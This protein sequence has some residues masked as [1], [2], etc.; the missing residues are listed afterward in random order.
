MYYNKDMKSRIVTLVSGVSLALLY[1]AYLSSTIDQADLRNIRFEQWCA[2]TAVA[3]LYLSLLSSSLPGKFTEN[4]GN[5]VILSF[6]FGLLHGSISFFFLL[7]GFEGLAFLNGKWILAITLSTSALLLLLFMALVHFF[8]GWSKSRP[9]LSYLAYLAGTMLMVHAI[10]VGTHFIDLSAAIPFIM[11][12]AVAIL[13]VVKALRFGYAVAG[14]VGL[15][16]LFGVYQLQSGAFKSPG[17]HSNHLASATTVHST[18]QAEP[19]RPLVE[20]EVSLKFEFFNPQNGNKLTDF[21]I[22][23][24]KLQHLIIVDQDLKYF[25]HVHPEFDGS[26]FT[27]TT[28]FPHDSVYRLYSETYPNGFGGQNH[29]FTLAVGNPPTSVQKITPDPNLT[30]TF[31]RYKVSLSSDQGGEFDSNLMSDSNQSLVFHIETASGQLVSDLQPY[32]GAY[33]HLV[34]IHQDTY[35]Y[36]HVHPMSTDPGPNVVFMPAGKI[37]PGIYRVFGQFQHNGEL[38]VADFTIN[39]E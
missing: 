8:S 11:S 15:L 16:A 32:L 29:L 3:F 18:F 24:D 31:G 22:I 14:I 23:H 21:L 10:L 1:F 2:L 34:M 25:N 36:A 39:V 9:W 7:G 27:V 37:S 35:E 26:G 28:A 30:K 4:Q 17:V 33:G 19:T 12:L 5:F 20:E 6:L 13:L 38:F